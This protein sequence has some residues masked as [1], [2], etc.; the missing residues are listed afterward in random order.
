MFTLLGFLLIL[1]QS[2]YYF[3]IDEDLLAWRT[4]GNA[5]RMALEMGLHRRRSLMDN[6]K[7]PELQ[8]RATKVFWCVYALDRRWSF[9]TGLSFALNERDIDPELPEPVSCGIQ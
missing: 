9:G 3:Q 7:S 6:Y 1:S 2:V 8:E 4:I 5:S